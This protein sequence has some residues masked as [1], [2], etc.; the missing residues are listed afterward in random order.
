MRDTLPCTC[1]RLGS[2]QEG[3]RLVTGPLRR[4][5]CGTGIDVVGA[6]TPVEHAAQDLCCH[7]NAASVWV[8]G[9]VPCHQPHIL[10]LLTE[11][12]EF[13][14]AESLH[15]TLLVNNTNLSARS[16]Q[17][18]LTLSSTPPICCSLIRCYLLSDKLPL[19]KQGLHSSPETG[20]FHAS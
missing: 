12:S 4:R 5:C 10:K 19:L 15:T 1:M 8:Y 7:D 16:I 6:H 18:V 9:D 17:R 13:L 20:A 11:L 3:A 2:Y 14:V